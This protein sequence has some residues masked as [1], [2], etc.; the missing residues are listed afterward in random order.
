MK[1]KL[2]LGMVALTVLLSIISYYF[3]PIHL[4]I[5]LSPIIIGS[6]IILSSTILHVIILIAIW[7]LLYIFIISRGI[8]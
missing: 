7:I 6:L 1:W 4:L 3:Y 5:I 2:L 8:F